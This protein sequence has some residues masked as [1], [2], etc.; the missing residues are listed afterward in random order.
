[1]LKNYLKIAWRN[2]VNNPVFTTINVFGLTVGISA[3]LVIFLIV[4]FELSFDKFHKD[5]ERIYRVYTE[6]KGV[7]NGFNRGVPDPLPA[8][9]HE[10]FSGIESSVH[11][12]TY[13][14]TVTIKQ[15]EAEPLHFERESN[16]IIT[17]PAYFNVFNNYEWLA[18]NAEASLSAPYQLVLTE[19]KARKFF[20]KDI[21]Y[22]QLLGRELIY[23]DSLVLSLSGIVKDII[24]NTDLDFTD[25]ISFAT[26]EQTWLKD[27]YSFTEWGSTN[28]HS[29]FFIK[30]EKGV[31][32]SNLEPQLET[33][34]EKALEF[35]PEN[36][37]YTGWFRLQPLSQLH[38]D[39]DLGIFDNSTRTAA[40]MPTLRSLI[41]I[42]MML[43][44]IASVNFINL[45]T[46]QATRRA[47]EIGVRKVMG[48]SRKALIFQFLS[49]S[50][51][52]SLLA[53]ILAL[54]L[55]EMA[56]VFFHEFIP[57]GLALNI[58]DFDT[59]V[60]LLAMVFIVGM[61]SG[62]YP[63]FVIS[64]YQPVKALKDKVYSGSRSTLSVFLRKSLTIFQFTFSQALIA[65][66]IVVTLQIGFMM[67]K[68]LGF[69]KE[70]IVYFHTPWFEGK[71]K[72][73]VL[74]NEL[75]KLSA[76]KEVSL[77]DSPPATKGY[78]TNTLIYKYDGGEYKHNVHRKVGDIDYISFYGLQLLS[79][80]NFETADELV[81]NETYARK[82]G[83]VNP[84]DVLNEQIFTGSDNP[85]IVVGVVKDFHFQSMHHEIQPMALYYGRNGSCVGLK[86]D[87][88]DKE[89]VDVKTALEQVTAAWKQVY[90][91]QTLK[92]FFMDE[93]VQKFYESEQKTAKLVNTATA[94]AI[95]IS[96]LGLFGLASFTTVQRTKE[97]GVRKVMGATIS[98]IVLLISKDFIK[99]VLVAFFIAA[100]LAYWFSQQWIS[101]F[102]YRMELD[103]WIFIITGLLS[104]LIAFVTLSYQ[105]LKAAMTDPVNSLRYE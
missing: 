104:V 28:S 66:A 44:L 69:D 24:Y 19:S 41:I 46:A 25:F 97:I 4:N 86:F 49:E 81:I 61:V 21:S 23:N 22:D 71:S 103:V 45:S 56:L 38:F 7:F 98:S 8:Y 6:F 82:L 94:I 70:A 73:D 20:G 17:S 34:H 51:F 101:D 35:N 52:L 76:L 87:S 5:G 99:L 102:A 12:H 1:M 14:A 48:G 91:D 60:F 15:H 80:R 33:M 27:N 85:K 47:K 37:D 65:C 105:A 62:L 57:K 26:V 39:K 3:C 95:I 63:A 29:Q 93:A 77:H 42:A 30:L 18:G 32:L 92:Y 74:L 67:N 78:N 88:G 16:M 64:S 10:N 58:L 96:C 83:F 13:G 40:H 43:L 54:P 59:I 50:T 9:V 75:N 84:E 53:V 11:F 100:P 68:E 36:N 89:S 31:T 2:I 79:G 90:P 72:R 55:S